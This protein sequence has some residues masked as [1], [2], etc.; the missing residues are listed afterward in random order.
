MCALPAEVLFATSGVLRVQNSWS[1]LQV[2]LPPLR[3]L[4]CAM[5]RS[6]ATDMRLQM[7]AAET[8]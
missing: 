8:S 4:L 2:A 3:L 7:Q 6:K 5:M 1:S